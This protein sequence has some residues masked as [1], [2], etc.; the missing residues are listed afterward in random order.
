[1]SREPSS[2][3]HVPELEGLRRRLDRQLGEKRASELATAGAA[4]DLNAA[5]AYARQQIDL[6]RRDPAPPA[7]Q[8]RARAA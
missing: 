8:A 5:A 2:F 7:R 3:H 4:M 6:A 1:M